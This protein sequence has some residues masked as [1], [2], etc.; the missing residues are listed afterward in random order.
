MTGE[1]AGTRDLVLWL[2]ILYQFNILNVH[3]RQ[4]EVFNF[5]ENC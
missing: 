1:L 3:F 5:H 4:H 2:N